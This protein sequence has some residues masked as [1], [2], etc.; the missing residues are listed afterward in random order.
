[1]INIADLTKPKI[2][3][4]RRIEVGMAKSNKILIICI[5]TYPPRQCGIATFS[6]DLVTAYNNLFLPEIEIRMVAM[7]APKAKLKYQKNV[8]FTIEQDNPKSYILAA[9]KL[10]KD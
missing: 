8:L 3:G 4:R 1:M 6:Q 9:R 5:G 7:Q 10:N 2:C